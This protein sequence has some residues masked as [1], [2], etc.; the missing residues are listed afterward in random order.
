MTSFDLKDCDFTSTGENSYFI[1][2]P[3]HQVIL[4]GEEDGEKL[5]V[6]MTVLDETKVVDGVETRVV[7]EKE[8]KVKKVI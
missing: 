6:I 8:R 1:L 2:K 7:E 4:E 3:G 5:Q